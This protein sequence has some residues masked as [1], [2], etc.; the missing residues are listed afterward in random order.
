VGVW[1][2]VRDRGHCPGHAGMCRYTRAPAAHM[3]PPS[4][5]TAAPA[6]T[7]T[8]RVRGYTHNLYVRERTHAQR[9]RERPAQNI[10]RTRRPLCRL[11]GAGR[12]CMCVCVGRGG[13]AHLC[14]PVTLVVGEVLRCDGKGRRCAERVAAG[15]VCQHIHIG[16]ESA[17]VP[18]YHA[19]GQGGAPLSPRDRQRERERERERRTD[20]D[21][22]TH[23][24]TQSRARAHSSGRLDS[25]AEPCR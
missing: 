8:E 7:P 20:Q 25:H 3:A 2:C 22:N 15:K 5:S 19:E 6:P 24:H 1:V 17:R 9:E 16:P 13:K 12:M 23:L 14:E 10:G 21:I 4:R 11:L 18:V